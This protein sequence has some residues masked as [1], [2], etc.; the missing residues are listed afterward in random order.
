MEVPVCNGRRTRSTGDEV[1]RQT[2]TGPQAAQHLGGIQSCQPMKSV[3]LQ[4]PDEQFS[5]QIPD[6]GLDHQ[7]GAIV[8]ILV[9]LDFNQD[10]G[11][12]D[13]FAYPEFVSIVDFIKDY[14][15]EYTNETDFWEILNRNLVAALLTRVIPTTFGVEYSLDQVVDA[16]GVE[17]QVAPGSSL[18]NFPRQSRVIGSPDGDEIAFAEGFS[19]QIPN[20]GLDHQGGAIV[21]LRV[22]LDFKKDVAVA[23]P[24]AYPE[25]VSIVNFIKDYLVSYPN[26]TDFWEIL[27]RNL[28]TAL[29]TQTIPT[30]FGVE[31][32][33][34]ELVDSVTV[35]LQVKSGSSLVNFNRAS[36]VTGSPNGVEIDFDESFSFEISDYGLDHQGGA[37]VDILVDLDFKD[38]VGVDNPF[39]YPEF[40][41]IVNFIKAYLVS[42]SNETDFWE[43]LNK[44]L[45][46][47]LLTGV[48]PT[49]FGV[50]YDLGE[51]VDSLTVELQVEA[52][53]SLVNFNRASQVIGSPDGEQID[54]DESFSFEI[55]DYGLDHQG[56]AIVDIDVELE[57]KEGIGAISP[58]DYP[59][60]VSIVNFIKDYLVRYPNET[61]FWEILNKNLAAALLTEAI[62]TTFGVE[63][64]LA[65]V[66][67]TVT[68]DIQVQSGSS[69]VNFPRASSVSQ[70]VEAGAE[71]TAIGQNLFTMS[72]PD[73]VEPILRISPSASTSQTVHD[74]AVFAVDDA[75]GRIDGLN[76]GEPGYAQVALSRARSVL[77]FLADR[78]DGFDPE[79]LSR[80]LQS[81]NGETF[82]FLLIRNDSLDAVRLGNDVNPAVL[83]GSSDHLRITATGRGS[84]ALAWIDGSASSADAKELVFQLEASEAA[85]PLGNTVQDQS[86]AELIDL[87][88]LA[89]DSLV[90]ASFEVYREAAFD[91][92]VGFYAIRDLQGTI[93]DPLTGELLR[94]GDK[95]YLKLAVRNRIAGLD[96]RVAN[97]AT[98]NV[99]ASLQGGS[100]LA[101]LLVVNGEPGWLEDDNAANDPAVY[102]PFVAANAD[103]VDHIRL[104]ADNTFG[105][106]D[107]PG[108]GDLDCNDLIVRATLSVVEATG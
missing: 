100:L 89:P 50:E 7:G 69:L 72:S 30:S 95:G 99:E 93:A 74:L 96:L 12:T 10:V 33:L 17:I 32:Q 1:L 56:G 41:S 55:S 20:Y 27:N 24:F 59:E 98:T 3:A 62:P 44:N 102:V 45:V 37:I 86:Q 107:L 103:R 61:D 67:D 6:Y 25:F 34:D 105:F 8:D 22:D 21:D 42:Y 91:N 79:N 65:D 76:P 36:E 106:E 85:K 70:S 15:I 23:D 38:D 87:R 35:D 14:L 43:I 68:V 88:E 19:F 73:G 108:G 97:Q 104:L 40:V 57:F 18:V 60:F 52:G 58:F 101:P 39:A 75:Q 13:P 94:P 47:T 83:F 29:L 49:T 16:L 81:E 53:S 80:S 46:T 90:K 28:V 2:P 63:Y 9:D 11:A 78:P 51:L 66:V 82:S 84:Y 64:H 71:L 31:Y 26:E 54:F 4:S 77:S 48:I 5:F 92:F